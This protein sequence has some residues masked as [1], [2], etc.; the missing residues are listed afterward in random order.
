MKNVVALRRRNS[1]PFSFAKNDE[2]GIDINLILGVTVFGLLPQAVA[3]SYYG[4]L[5]AG[6]LGVCLWVGISL[7]FVLRRFFPYRVQTLAI[8]SL[9]RPRLFIDTITRKAA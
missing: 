7:G 9:S 6:I 4:V 2:R 8:N 3:I 1:T 5:L